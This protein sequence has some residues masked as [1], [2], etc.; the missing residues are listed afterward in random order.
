MNIINTLQVKQQV[1]ETKL[2]VVG[3]NSYNMIM[4]LS[5]Q[6]LT[7]LNTRLRCFV[8]SFTRPSMSLKLQC[9]DC[10][11]NCELYTLKRYFN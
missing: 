3:F 2:N 9:G 4:R 5:P 7:V 8:N 6:N 1:N 10:Q 11:N